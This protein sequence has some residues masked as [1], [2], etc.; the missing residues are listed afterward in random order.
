MKEGN[1]QKGGQCRGT[2]KATK[3]GGVKE[4]RE[5]EKRNEQGEMHLRKKGINAVTSLHRLFS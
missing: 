1:L 3:T 2:S 4:L 5:D